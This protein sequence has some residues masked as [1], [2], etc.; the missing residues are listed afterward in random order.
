MYSL[1]FSWDQYIQLQ[2]CRAQLI[3]YGLNTLSGPGLGSGHYIGA[4]IYLHIS[5]KEV[6]LLF[7]TDLSVQLEQFQKT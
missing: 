7:P 5:Y 2:P 3:P 4:L 1:L 6:R